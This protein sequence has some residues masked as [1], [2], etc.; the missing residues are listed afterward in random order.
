MRWATL[1]ASQQDGCVQAYIKP[2]ADPPLPRTM[3]H[4]TVTA[5]MDYM[6]H[7]AACRA[8]QQKPSVYSMTFND[9]AHPHLPHQPCCSPEAAPPA[10]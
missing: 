1:H 7:G 8:P 3:T 2:H 10:N 9:P 6:A 4:S 5:H